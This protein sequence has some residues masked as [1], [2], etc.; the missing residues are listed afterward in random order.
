MLNEKET[1][2]LLDNFLLVTKAIAS[3]DG[4][5]GKH[6]KLLLGIVCTLCRVLQEPPPELFYEWIEYHHLEYFHKD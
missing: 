1:R 4:R 2:D 3:L 6:T 5:D